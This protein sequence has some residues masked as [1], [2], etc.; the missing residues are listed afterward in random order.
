MESNMCIHHN[1][2]SQSFFAYCLDCGEVFKT[3]K[4]CRHN[5]IKGHESCLQC[6][7]CGEVLYREGEAWF[8]DLVAGNH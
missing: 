7:D 4:L 6:A 5:N 1:M 2:R 3:T 8:S